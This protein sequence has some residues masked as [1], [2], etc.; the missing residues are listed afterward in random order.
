MT[1]FYLIERNEMFAIAYDREN[2]TLV[3]VCGP[4]DSSDCPT[5]GDAIDLR[6]WHYDSGDG[7][8]SLMPYDPDVALLAI[9]EEA[10]TTAEW[11]A[12]ADE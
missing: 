7:R 3:G 1:T 6:G 5:P 12:D 10:E 8:D 9:Q 11:F 4:L 2:D